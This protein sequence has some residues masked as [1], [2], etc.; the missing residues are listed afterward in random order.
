[1]ETYT[2]EG[3]QRTHMEVNVE[4]VHKAKIITLTPEQHTPH[5]AQLLVT[6]RLYVV[7][8]PAYDLDP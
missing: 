2:D 1:M 6:V 3:K 7:S 8:L 4:K 5:I